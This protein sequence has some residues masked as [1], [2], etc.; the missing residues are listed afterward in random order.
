[1]WMVVQSRGTLRAAP[2]A[3]GGGRGGSMRM[4]GG[5]ASDQAESHLGTVL[6]EA[7]RLLDAGDDEGAVAMLEDNLRQACSAMAF[8]PQGVLNA[9][10]GDVH[11]A[12]GRLEAALPHYEKAAAALHEAGDTAAEA[13]ALLR[14]GDAQRALK[15]VGAATHSYSASAALY[16]MLDDPRGAAHGE[17]LLA[18]LAAGVQ[19][20]IAEKHYRQA[21]ELYREA[22][23]REPPPVPAAAPA[24]SAEGEALEGE[25]IDAVAPADIV[26]D[27]RRID[28]AR[29]LAIAE[30]G[31]ERLLAGPVRDADAAPGVWTPPAPPA[32]AADATTARAAADKPAAAVAAASLDTTQAAPIVLGILGL[33][34]CALILIATQMGSQALAIGLASVALAVGVTLVVLRRSS[35]VSP[36]LTYVAGGTAWLL[37]LASAAV[38]V[39]RPGPPP[40]PVE[41]APPVRVAGEPWTPERQR[42]DFERELNAAP[43]DDLRTR[44]DILRRHGEFERSQSD[45][46]RCL[47]LWERSVDLFREAGAAAPAAEVAMAIGDVHMRSQ[48]PAP[49]RERFAAAAELYDEGHDTPGMLR[50]LR[51]R[52]D[53]ERALHRW[54]EATT[55]YG[56]ALRTARSQRAVDEEV[57]LVQRLAMVEQ[58]AGRVEPA[59]ALFYR[60]LQLSSDNGPL[61]ARAWLALANFEASLDQDDA[62]RRAF[63]RAAT[64]AGSE[65]DPDLEALGLR[66]R[67]AY[68]QRRGQLASARGRYEVAIR[69]ARAREA[70]I[71]EALTRLHAAALEAKAGEI[72]AARDLYASAEA[73]FAQRPRSGGAARV[74]LG[75]GDLDAQI[76]D[77]EGAERQY[78][79]A[80]E[81]AVQADHTGLQIA[82]M[83][84][85]T[86]LLAAREP[87]AADGYVERAAALRVEAF[88]APPAAS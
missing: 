45:R 48:R 46:R 36:P 49:A 40:K 64:L 81:L 66:D 54:A 73:L 72:V 67:A 55:T 58:A 1:M 65:R 29:M 87:E 79:R 8:A 32:A 25:G 80:L 51:R 82:A 18:E 74:A 11:R 41:V 7:E 33:G 5:G 75:L 59:R 6:A 21:I 52:G 71:A 31:L 69:L 30:R 77:V 61:H 47:E 34:V 14:C 88:G 12:A 78:T 60:A 13:G 84:R 43:A 20:D 10:L 16:Q 19:R 37:L 57:L 17:F 15:R 23:E 4:D 24:P 27:P 42:A 50:A 62:A 9:A 28:S 76:G 35:G 56:E 68:E 44:A 2:R 85:L 22:A 86:R 70:R 83:E 3:S 53:A 63:E 26:T 38:P 39:L